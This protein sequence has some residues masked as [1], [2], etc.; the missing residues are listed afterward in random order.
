MEDR[1]RAGASQDPAYPADWDEVERI[2]AVSFEMPPDSL[3][4]CGDWERSAWA[5]TQVLGISRQRPSFSGEG[6]WHGS[7][8]KMA[9][10]S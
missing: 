4:P 10:G 8:Y 7:V 9:F 2:I 3:C 1:R 6:H 5:G